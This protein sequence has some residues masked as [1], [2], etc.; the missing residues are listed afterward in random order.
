MKARNIE[1]FLEAVE[2]QSFDWIAKRLTANDTGATGGHQVGVYL[3][4]FFFE[5]AFPDICRR[6]KLNPKD[7]F[8]TVEFPQYGHST[9]DV[10]ATYYNNKFF[11][12]IGAKKKYDEFR[13]TNW[14]GK[15]SPVQDPEN[16]GALFLLAFKENKA[17]IWITKDVEE[18][19]AIEHWLGR[20]VEPSQ[21]PSSFHSSTRG[22]R[23]VN[24]DALVHP[25][26]RQKFPTGE[27]L[28][29][30]IVEACPAHSF[31]SMDDLLLRRRELEFS[32]F[33]R[34]EELHVLPRIHGGFNSVSDFLNL[35]NSI[36]NRR[37]SRSGSSL[38]HHLADIFLHKRL[39]FEEQVLTERRNRP[40]FLFPGL[41]AYKNDR[42]PADKLFMLAAKTCCKERW[43]Q[44]L[45]E[46]DRISLKHLFTLQEGV[47][48]NQFLQMQQQGVQLVVPR[49][50][51]RSFPA[52]VRPLLLTLDSFI[53]TVSAYQRSAP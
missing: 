43:R 20:D 13:L 28:F 37:K 14:G 5:K 7:S 36:T 46:A 40:D 15:K 39:D 49:K 4:R 11:P 2:R 51:I 3:P 41:K 32:L 53:E 17:L 16:T 22:V 21:F 29:R 6:D 1:E 44:I 34:V 30:R 42:H 18:E 10:V 45:E 50:N 25:D 19:N 38:E 9:P 52:K 27:A 24:L 48:I 33:R 31:H 12:E 8:E 23:G 35:A 47:S 26:W